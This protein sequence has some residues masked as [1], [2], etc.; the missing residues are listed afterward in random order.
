MFTSKMNDSASTLEMKKKKNHS[1]DI[2]R[3][4]DTIRIVLDD[5]RRRNLVQNGTVI[6]SRYTKISLRVL[7]TY[8]LGA[9]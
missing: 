9:R 4:L 5:T 1:S 6:S 2:T 8:S 3:F 7:N